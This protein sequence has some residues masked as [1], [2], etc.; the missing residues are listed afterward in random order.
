MKYV[1]ILQSVTGEHFYTGITDDLERRLAEHNSG[2]VTH[3]VKVRPWKIKSYV[4]ICGRRA[5]NCL[6]EVFEVRIGSRFCQGK[7][8]STFRGFAGHIPIRLRPPAPIPRNSFI[9]NGWHPLHTLRR[10]LR[11]RGHSQDARPGRCARCRAWWAARQCRRLHPVKR[12]LPSPAGS[13]H[14]ARS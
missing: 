7:A 9:V 1:Y 12:R 13:C 6:R 11:V 4:A 8:I 3:Y 10:D 5:C 14:R 2:A